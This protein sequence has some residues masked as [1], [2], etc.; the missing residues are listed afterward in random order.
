MIQFFTALLLFSLVY[1]VSCSGYMEIRLKSEYRQEATIEISQGLSTT[2]LSVSTTYLSLPTILQAGKVRKLGK[3]P[4]EFN[5]TMYTLSINGGRVEE[6]GIN[7]STH[8]AHFTPTRGVLSPK[9]LHLPLNGLELIFE[10]DKNYR[11]S[12]CDRFCFYSCDEGAENNNLKVNTDYSVD[13]T[14]LP[15]LVKRLKESTK[16]DNEI[17]TIETKEDDEEEEEEEI[18]KPRKSVFQNLFKSIM[19]L[20]DEIVHRESSPVSIGISFDNDSES[21]SSWDPKPKERKDPY[22]MSLVK[23]ILLDKSAELDRKHEALTK[24][25]GSKKSIM[26]HRESTPSR[27]AVDDGPVGGMDVSKMLGPLMSMGSPLPF[28]F[29]R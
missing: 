17:R 27:F 29:G 1:E 25:S 15:E 23:S 24:D 28:L 6:L 3:F 11:G 20:Q 9:Q 7:G 16:V 4:I 21:K 19:A 10:C 2:Y 18:S 8:T 22:P 12:K 5:G 26:K 14:K 13:L